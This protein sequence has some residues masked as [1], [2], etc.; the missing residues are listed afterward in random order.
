MVDKTLIVDGHNFLFRG[1]YGVPVQ[2]KYSDGTQINGIYGF[3]SLLRNLVE[4]LDSSKLYIVFDSET[5][6]K[7]KLKINSDYKANRSYDTEVFHQLSL[8]KKCL[9]ILGIS[10][11]EDPD[12]EADDVIAQI[13]TVEQKRD[14][15]VYIASNDFD[16]IQLVSEKVNVVRGYHGKIDLYDINKVNKKFGINPLQYVDY[17]SLK[18]DKS[19]NVSGITGIGH[20][21][22]SH[23][24]SN[25]DNIEGIFKKF[26]GLEDL[27]KNL[28]MDKEEFLI[29]TREFLRM[30]CC[31]DNAA[32]EYI[33]TNLTDNLI[34]QKMGIFLND[35]WDAISQN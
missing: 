13:S 21:R 8:I 22:A 7:D 29:E 18:G 31:L 20:K 35:N 27:Y 23:L 1:Y 30:D 6:T 24:V 33:S 32:E 10:W 5:G 9:D 19:D 14:E 28:L 16:F 26:D 12:T 3:F 25:Y 11:Y 34:P 15:S 2:A 17:L 4:Y